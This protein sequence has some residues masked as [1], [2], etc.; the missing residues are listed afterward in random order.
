MTRPSIKLMREGKFAAEASIDLI[1]GQDG[2]SPYLSVADA[3]K[4]D[5]MR[6]ALR[7]GDLAAASRRV[8]EL[9]P[10]S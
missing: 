3:T 7:S 5:D 10:L 4:L 6:R 2:W 9:T 1:E 8:F